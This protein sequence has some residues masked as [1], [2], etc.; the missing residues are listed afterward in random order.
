MVLEA[1]ISPLKAEKKPWETFTVGFIYSALAI[2]L[3][4]LIFEEQAS[5]VSVFLISIAA[6]PLVY[7]TFKREETK[8]MVMDNER[9]ILKEH[10][11]A[12]SF[13]IFLYS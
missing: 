9:G 3:S 2:A 13:L 5:L 11:K 4:I 12:I 10:S 1:I 7:S 6:L 8:D